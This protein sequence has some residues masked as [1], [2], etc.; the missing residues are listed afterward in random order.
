MRGASFSG[1][2]GAVTE[3]VLSR[4]RSPYGNLPSN[5]AYHAEPHD[6]PQAPLR[7][8]GGREG[9]HAGDTTIDVLGLAIH[10][11]GLGFL[12]A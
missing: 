7:T 2:A 5:H 4:N 10:S 12:R 9:G 8:R 1:T 3:T 11:A 6:G